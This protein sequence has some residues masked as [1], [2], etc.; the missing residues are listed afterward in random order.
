MEFVNNT[1][2][3]AFLSVMTGLRPE[4]R[5]ALVTAKATFLV[6]GD[7]QVR[8]DREAPL[9]VFEQDQDSEAGLLPADVQAKISSRF[10][11]MVIGSAHSPTDDPVEEVPVELAVGDARRAIIVSGDRYW[12]GSGEGAR[13]GAPKPFRSM[14]M[15]WERAFGGT[16]EVEI[17][18]DAFLDV[19][20]ARNREG[21]GFDHLAHVESLGNAFNC[22]DGFPK[23]SKD[24]P[25]PNLE[26]PQARVRTWSDEPLAV[27]WAPSPSASGIFQ[28]RLRRRYADNPPREPQMGD[29]MLQERAHP[30]WIIDTPPE[31]TLVRLTGMCP[32]GAELTFKLPPARAIAEIRIGKH[33]RDA[34]LH[35]QALILLPE[36]RRFC[37][38]FRG[39]QRYRYTSD[40]ERVVRLRVD[41]GW[42]PAPKPGPKGVGVD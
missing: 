25:L 17:D 18:H 13:I 12:E 2:V 21:R 37:L 40:E 33:R 39:G 41:R 30:D 7:G 36:K 1:P 35:P 23:F 42:V 26:D 34:E 10:E 4:Q 6:T 8:L 22:P 38:V 16:M 19:S 11:V 28:E 32:D 9:E 3:P 24:R 14:P 31:K 5:G 15:T 27:C 29:P 20:D